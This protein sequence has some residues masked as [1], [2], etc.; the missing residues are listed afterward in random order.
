MAK[1]KKRKVKTTGA[2]PRRRKGSRG[3]RRGGLRGVS[4]SLKSGM[5][6][7]VQP[8]AIFGGIVA[9]NFAGNKLDEML[10]TSENPD[11]MKKYA[12]PAAQLVAG[13]ALAL[14][15][16]KKNAIAKGIGQGMMISGL[17]SGVKVVAKKDLFT[18]LGATPE[19][20]YQ[21]TQEALNRMIE[22]N[23]QLP[24]LP[25]MEPNAYAQASNI[26]A[27]IIAA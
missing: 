9:A 2:N 26:T 24:P 25:G 12:K 16:G 11:S 20:E 13:A 18:G 6:E 14:T 4:S 8:L 22:Q 7:I 1:A 21:E 3:K 17:H 27:P 10:K 23:R 19:T 15:V 5:N